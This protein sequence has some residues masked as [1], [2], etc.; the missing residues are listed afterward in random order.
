MNLPWWVWCL[1]LCWLLIMLAGCAE[2]WHQAGATQQDFYRDNSQC[3][4][5]SQGGHTQ[6]T[7]GNDPATAG[8]NQ[9]QA[10]M[11]AYAASSIYEQCMLGKGWHR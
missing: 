2:P 6:V 10:T 11:A 1:V 5:M 7:A 9:G 8:Y 3:L 4:A